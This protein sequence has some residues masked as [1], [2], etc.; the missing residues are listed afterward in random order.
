MRKEGAISV[1]K[2]SWLGERVKVMGCLN[3]YILMG[4]CGGKGEEGD[5]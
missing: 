3:P 5:K 1:V 2:N 4:G